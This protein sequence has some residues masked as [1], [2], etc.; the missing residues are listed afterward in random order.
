MLMLMMLRSEDIENHYVFIAEGAGADA[1]VDDNHAIGEESDLMIFT[2]TNM[3]KET[4]ERGSRFIF[5]SSLTLSLF[6]VF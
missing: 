5:S 6:N 4:V 2:R 1:D 3:E